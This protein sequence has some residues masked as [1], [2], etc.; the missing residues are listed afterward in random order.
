MNKAF[1]RESDNPSDDELEDDGPKLPP[2]TKNYMTHSCANR[3]RAEL[4]HL[5]YKERPE[6]AQMV[7]WAAQNGDRSEN[8]DY[9][10]NKRRLG[11]IDRRLRYLAK[12]LENA[13]IID[14]TTIKSEQIL[15]GATVT[16]S[17]QDGQEV[18]YSIVGVDEVDVKKGKISWQSPLANSL[19]KAKEGDVVNFRSPKGAREI[20]IMSIRYIAI[21]D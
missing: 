1:T 10:Y 21:P 3:M 15:F 7:N 4:K 11:Q 14:P 20:E 9:T 18:T 17:D 2:G 19:F 6:T 12:R 5:R 8:A 16:I 13:E